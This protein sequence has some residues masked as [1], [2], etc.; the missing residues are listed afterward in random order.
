MRVSNYYKTPL[1]LLNLLIQLLHLSWRKLLLV[2][3][4]VVHFVFSIPKVQ[5]KHVHRVP[6]ILKIVI[7]VHYIFSS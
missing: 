7:P 2:K 5:P 4:K 1:M 3:L 6:P